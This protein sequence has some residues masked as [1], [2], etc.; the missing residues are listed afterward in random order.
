M[1][2][3]PH[4]FVGYAFGFHQPTLRYAVRV[5]S[6]DM[7][8]LVELDRSLSRELDTPYESVEVAAGL[9]ALARLMRWTRAVL[10]KGAHPVFEPARLLLPNSVRPAGDQLN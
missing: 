8:K 9:E 10:E 1:L 3:Q 5:V 6:G 2:A 7:A 4:A